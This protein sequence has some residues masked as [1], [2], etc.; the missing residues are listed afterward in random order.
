MEGSGS[1]QIITDPDL[2]GPKLT[3][4]GSGNTAR[5]LY[6]ISLLAGVHGFLRWAQH[7]TH[8]GAHQSQPVGRRVR[9]AGEEKWRCHPL[10]PGC[11][12]Q[13]LNLRNSRLVKK[14]ANDWAFF[15]GFSQGIF[16]LSWL[17]NTAPVSFII[18]KWGNRKCFSNQFKM[19][20]SCGILIS[21]YFYYFA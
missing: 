17:H 20:I 2:G 3:G 4:S 19:Y 5:N 6:L 12:C 21:P 13:H 9:S 11:G 7:C 8:G 14:S 16:W 15:C 1:L 10:C 18:M